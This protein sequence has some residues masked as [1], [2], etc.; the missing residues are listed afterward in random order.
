MASRNS[1]KSIGNV[2]RDTWSGARITP[3][4]EQQALGFHIGIVMD[5]QDDQ[6]MGRLWVYIPAFSSKRFDENSVPRYG[7]Q[8]PDRS[9]DTGNLNYDAR[10]RNGWIQCYPLFPF[11]GSDEYRVNVGPDGRNSKQGDTNSYGFWYQ[12]RNGDS[13]AI[14][15]ENADPSRG[16]WFGGVPKQYRNF[17]VPGV[18]GTLRSDLKDSVSGIPDEVPDDA[19]YPAMDAA[20]TNANPSGFEKFPA[21]TMGANLV[22]SGMIRDVNRGAS[23]SGARRESPSYVTGFKSPGWVYESEQHKK[24]TNGTLFSSRRDQLGAHNTTGH[25]FVMDDHPDY[26]GIR[27]RTSYGSQ[28]LF[29]DSS[30]TP[31]IYVNTPR[32]KVWI[33][34]VDSGNLHVYAKGSISLHAEQDINLTAN[35][36]V[37]IEALQDMRVLVR[38]NQEMRVDGNTDW[39]FGQG[40]YTGQIGNFEVVYHG[41]KDSTVNQ[42]LHQTVLQDRF[43]KIGAHLSIESGG[44]LDFLSG[45]TQRMT[46]SDDQYFVAG[47]I[48]AEQAGSI[49]MNSGFDV[50]ASASEEASTPGFSPLNRV[51]GAPNVEQIHSGEEPGVVQ[52]LASIVPQH[53]P[54]PGR[55]GRSRGFSGYV[56]PGAV[57]VRRG[58]TTRNATSPMDFSGLKSNT[59][60]GHFTGLPYNTTNMG[61]A[62]QYSMDGVEPGELNPASSYAGISPEMEEFIKSEEGFSATPYRDAGGNWA[63]GY[64]HNIRKG[65]VINGVVVDDAY[66]AQ[67]DRTNGKALVIN[68]AEADSLFDQDI[69]R[70]EQAVRDNVTTDI[71]QGQFDAMTSFSYNVGA[72][73]FRDSTMLEQLN[74]GNFEAVPQEW[75]R[76]VNA[77]GQVVDGLVSRRRSELERFFAS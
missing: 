71:T 35:R 45:G 5:D 14:M 19:L 64:G 8:T 3:S 63:V 9:T 57:A 44:D 47:G 62:P 68:E 30:D 50:P 74:S 20:R 77:D 24:D 67:L 15:F 32:G 61:E 43:D 54:W 26:Q 39:G 13:V 22:D 18:P 25:Q 53:Q 73:A 31:Y 38:R 76:W 37:N 12:P 21:T 36:N 6:F 60:P 42:D 29:D 75:M 7:S 66:L 52:H 16:Y 28:L 17:M 72:G 10:L 58:A 56:R 33:E 23:T 4:M 40:T 11:F 69:A 51:P 41:D 2:A 65:D 48:Y 34:M 49:F 27:I 46:A 55:S 70:F 59:G 1:K